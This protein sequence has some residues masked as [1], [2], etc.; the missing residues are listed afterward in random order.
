MTEVNRTRIYEVKNGRYDF[1]LDLDLIRPSLNAELI[2]YFMFGQ[3]LFSEYT[4]SNL[5]VFQ[6]ISEYTW[7]NLI[8]F[9]LI[10]EYT[11]SNLIVFQLISVRLISLKKRTNLMLLL[12]SLTWSGWSRL[13][14][15]WNLLFSKPNLP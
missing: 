15:Y 14:I 2:C 5:I 8:E 4:W 3:K 7:S 12:T 9:Q 1:K 13:F 6:L 11:W 10:S